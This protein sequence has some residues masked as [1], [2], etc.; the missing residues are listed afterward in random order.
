VPSASD[1]AQ[2]QSDDDGDPFGIESGRKLVAR[3]RAHADAISKAG[4]ELC[5]ALTD[6]LE[7]SPRKLRQQWTPDELLV[8]KVKLRRVRAA[9]EALRKAVADH[10]L[11]Q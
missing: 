5:M 4:G 9:Q 2:Q 1:S 11:T 3:W 10:L 8:A 6:L 7:R